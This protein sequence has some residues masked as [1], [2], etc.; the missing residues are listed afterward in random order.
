MKAT[1]AFSA[2]I[3]DEAPTPVAFVTGDGAV[4]ILLS[5]GDDLEFS[6]IHILMSKDKSLALVAEIERAIAKSEAS[7]MEAK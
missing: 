3:H 2:R 1:F 7:A 6:S 5:D 4:A